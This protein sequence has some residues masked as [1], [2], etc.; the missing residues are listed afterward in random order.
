MQRVELCRSFATI[1]SGDRQR[2]CGLVLKVRQLPHERDKLG[3][4]F[5]L[6]EI[7]AEINR[8]PRALRQRRVPRAANRDQIDPRQQGSVF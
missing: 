5:F 7:G 3:R 6:L 1:Y 4:V 8:V 2:I